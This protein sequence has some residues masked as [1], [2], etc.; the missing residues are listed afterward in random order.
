MQR[1]V[2]VWSLTILLMVGAVAACAGPT[3]FPL[4]ADDEPKTTTT[5]R[6][7]NQSAATNGLETPLLTA[8]PTTPP[9]VALLTVTDLK[10]GDSWVASD[11][12]EYRLGL[13]NAP[14]RNE[15]CGT[16]ARDFTAGFLSGGFT[17]DVYAVDRYD[18]QVAEVFDASGASL[19]VALAASGLGDG[20]YI[21]E[22]RAE[23]PDLAARLETALAGAPTPACRQ[24]TTTAPPATAPPATSPPVVAPV[25]FVGS[26]DNCHPAYSPCVPIQGTGSGSGGA[27]DLDCGQIGFA[28]TLNGSD[29]PYRLDREGDG[30]GC[31]DFG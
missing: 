29:D 14:E 7:E 26:G 20:R 27:N 11:G 12:R 30:R 21:E 28:V 16:A 1:G 13:I 25:P 31:E 4:G 2:R 18:R 10:D 22:F 23:N 5:R 8:P 17:A 15:P 6:S 19:N 3:S 24:P 9:A